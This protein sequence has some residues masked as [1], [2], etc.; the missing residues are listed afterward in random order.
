MSVGFHPTT[1]TTYEVRESFGQNRTEFLGW[2]VWLEDKWWFKSSKDT[3][4][5]EYSMHEIAK[6]LTAMN[7]DEP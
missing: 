5:S 3:V 2:L 4:I 6:R 7:N 1:P